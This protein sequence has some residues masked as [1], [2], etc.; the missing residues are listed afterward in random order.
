V[1]LDPGH[2]SFEPLAH[3][4]QAHGVLA[5][6]FDLHDGPIA[7][8]ASDKFVRWTNSPHQSSS[9]HLIIGQYEN[10]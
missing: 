6:A 5:L 7:H 1:N 9:G 4:Q 2:V 10:V 8:G 3:E